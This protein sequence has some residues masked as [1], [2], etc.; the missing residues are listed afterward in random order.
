MAIGGAQP[1]VMRIASDLH[2]AALDE[3]SRAR[4]GRLERPRF[5]TL[6]NPATVIEMQV[7]EDHMGDVA[8][9]HAE[10][11][12]P[13]YQPAVVM[14]ENLA[15]DRAQPVADPSIDHD[16]VITA[17]YERT[18]QVE[19]DPVLLVCWMLALPQLARHDAEHAAAVIAPDAV[20]QKCDGEIAKLELR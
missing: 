20:A 12:E 5:A 9:L 11:L 10:R 8:G 13:V 17:H 1:F 14:V 7:R 2:F 3:D 6:H 15:L 19:A 18:G 16:R 4:E